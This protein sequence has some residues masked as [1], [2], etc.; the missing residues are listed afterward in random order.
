LH[1]LDLHK[2]PIAF[3]DPEDREVHVEC[4]RLEVARKILQPLDWKRIYSVEDN[5]QLLEGTK[6]W[7]LLKIHRFSG[8]RNAFPKT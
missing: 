7:S 4:E 5:L 1:S 3:L 6:N 2:V 8:R